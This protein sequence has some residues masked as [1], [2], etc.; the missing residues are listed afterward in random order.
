MDIHTVVVLKTDIYCC[1]RQERQHIAPQPTQPKVGGL[2]ECQTTLNLG[3]VTDLAPPPHC[4][5]PAVIADKHRELLV[6]TTAHCNLEL[7]ADLASQLR[8]RGGKD[9]ESINSNEI[10][11]DGAGPVVS[12]FSRGVRCALKTKKSRVFL[13]LSSKQCMDAAVPIATVRQKQVFHVKY[14]KTRAS[15]P[16]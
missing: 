4:L 16:E 14:F 8:G 12:R 1:A 5:Q 3:A 15:T 6:P 13:P 11:L 7:T 2:G 10:H 9:S